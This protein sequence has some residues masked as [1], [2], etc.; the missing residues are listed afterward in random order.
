M[1][2][3]D[4]IDMICGHRTSDAEMECF[5]STHALPPLSQT[6]EQWISDTAVKLINSIP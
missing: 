5:Y 4:C 3:K 2:C 1:K 6:K